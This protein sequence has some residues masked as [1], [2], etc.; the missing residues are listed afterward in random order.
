MP[1]RTQQ[2]EPGGLLV[3]TV[4]GRVSYR[5]FLPVWQRSADAI[6]RLGK[7][8]VLIV[9][10]SFQG[11]EPS[12]GWGDTSFQEK[13]DRFIERIAIV[14]DSQWKDLVLA[15]VGKPFRTL[16]IQYFLP[17]QLVEARAWLG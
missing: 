7:I 16:P 8:K 9:L 4:S 14:G 12:E 3:A 13:Y 6:G 10:D 2:E 11:W 1:I 5:E 15:F 17:T